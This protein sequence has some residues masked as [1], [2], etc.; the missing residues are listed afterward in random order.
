MERDA[1]NGSDQ[2]FEVRPTMRSAEGGSGEKE[3]AAASEGVGSDTESRLVRSKIRAHFSQ[4]E[5]DPDLKRAPYLAN[6]TRLGRFDI[7]RHLGSGRYSDVYEALDSEDRNLVALKLLPLAVAPDI[8]R[9]FHREAKCLE[10]L[11]HDSIV[12]IYYHGE[13]EEFYFLSMELVSG[14]TVATLLSRFSG[15]DAPGPLVGESTLLGEEIPRPRTPNYFRWVAR[16]GRRIALALE[17]AHGSGIIHRDVKPSNLLFLGKNRWKVIDFGIVRALSETTVSAP[18]NQPGTPLYASPEQLD[19]QKK[20]DARSDLFSLGS[21]LYECLSLKHPF[22]EGPDEESTQIV[23]RIQSGKY[24]SLLKAEPTV[25]L[26]LIWIVEGC[27]ARRREE[28]GYATAQ[29][30]ADDLGRFLV[31]EKVWV[32][33][34]R[35]VDRWIGLVREHPLP[36]ILALVTVLLLVVSLGWLGQ[37]RAQRRATLL[38]QQKTY[39]QAAQTPARDHFDERMSSMLRAYR[40]APTS[41]IGTLCQEEILEWGMRLAIPP[42]ALEECAGEVASRTSRAGLACYS[43]NFGLAAKLYGGSGR[44]EQRYRAIVERLSQERVLPGPPGCDLTAVRVAEETG[45]SFPNAA[46]LSTEKEGER[47]HL[48]VVY[49]PGRLFWIDLAPRAESAWSSVEVSEL[50]DPVCDHCLAGGPNRHQG[51]ATLYDACRSE[52]LLLL[53]HG[54]EHEPTAEGRDRKVSHLLLFGIDSRGEIVPRM[55]SLEVRGAVDPK[56]VACADLDG[57]GKSELIVATSYPHRDG[58]LY[59]MSES[60]TRPARKIGGFDTRDTNVSS[61]AVLPSSSPRKPVRLFLGLWMQIH[62]GIQVVTGFRREEREG[63]DYRLVPESPPSWSP[64][65]GYLP[66]GTIDNLVLA[67]LDEHPGKELVVA[68]GYSHD[69]GDLFGSAYSRGVPDGIYGY[70]IDAS[71]LLPLDDAG[72]SMI[73][74]PRSETVLC[75]SSVLSMVPGRLDRVYGDE[76]VATVSVH[77]KESRDSTAYLTTYDSETHRLLPPLYFRLSKEEGGLRW[78]RQVLVDDSDGDG[79]DELIVVDRNRIVIRGESR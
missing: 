8:L 67:D 26:P 39:D 27:L 76:I 48:L 49:V 9:R 32:R 70:R 78:H 2:G 45:C 72:D 46:I 14:P 71:R 56:A 58:I 42:Q 22:V 29:D 61:V 17:H 30:L 79:L 44:S 38:A 68:K 54:K 60:S 24:R 1:K 3:E 28:R 16:M 31:G 77:L 37:N 65:L 64:E 21:T 33:P 4:K 53:V 57:D 5:R 75:R 6:G 41:P 20:I 63:D 66:F 43:G 18:G 15:S 59:A 7:V 10:D 51:I 19:G 23:E 34:R 12:K 62:P 52:P 36:A 11:K 25:P 47:R 35:P 73:P 69:R 40:A 13:L 74:L 55:P 50:L